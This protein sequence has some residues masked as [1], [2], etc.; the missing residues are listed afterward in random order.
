MDPKTVIR[1]RCSPVIAQQLSRDKAGEAWLSISCPYLAFL[2]AQHQVK[3]P[4]SL[5][6]PNYSQSIANVSSLAFGSRQSDANAVVEV[7]CFAQAP[8]VDISSHQHAF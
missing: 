6:F 7:M 3:V 5:C 1:L 8:P 4:P 2:M